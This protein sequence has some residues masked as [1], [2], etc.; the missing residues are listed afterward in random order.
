MVG[1]GWCG[2][3]GI[4]YYNNRKAKWKNC[5]SFCGYLMGHCTSIK[6]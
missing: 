4:Y 5:T 3:G 6:I 1:S 2:A